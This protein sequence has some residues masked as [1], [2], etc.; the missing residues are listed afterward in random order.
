[1]T[2]AA[3]QT[4]RSRT[5]L[6]NA[7]R[8][9]LSIFLLVLLVH[10]IDVTDVQRALLDARMT[11]IASAASLTIA[12]IGLQIFKWRYFVRLVDPET[13]NLETAASLLFG[14]TLGSLTPGQIGEFGGR[15]LHHSSIS[16]ATIVGLTLIDKVQMICIM[17]IAGIISICILYDSG[18]IFGT[19][20]AAA[21]A[22]FFLLV[23][24]KIH[25]LRRILARY[26]FRFLK[27]PVLQDLLEAIAIFNK[28]NL[29]VSFCFSVGFYVVV[30]VQMFLL[31]NAFS[32]VSAGHAFLGFAAMMLLKSLLPISLGDLGIREASSVYFYGLLGVS[33]ATALNASLLLFG[34]NILLPSLLGLLFIPKPRLDD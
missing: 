15:A 5:V 8:G 4:K 1:M 17:G 26:D 21:S 7:G 31:L 22:A 29:L 14:I 27:Y 6:L 28:T 2:A 11:F 25:E 24:F 18:M 20:V 34:C 9:L 13:T 12:N 19:A 33:A 10:F 23:F 3:R 16:A 32:P 30:Y